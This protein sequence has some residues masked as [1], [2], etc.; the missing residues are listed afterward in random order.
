MPVPPLKIRLLRLVAI[1]TGVYLLFVLALAVFQRKLMYLPDRC[2]ETVALAKARD[3]RSEPWRD[4]QGTII[5]WRHPGPPGKRPANRLI[6]FHGNAG[7]ALDRTPIIEGFE[8]LEKGALWEGYLFEYPGYGARPG[9]INETSFKKAGA[10]ALKQLQAED[11]R[12]IFVIGE[13]VGS[14]PACALARAEPKSVAGL[15]LITPFTS[16]ADAAAS[17]YPTVPV[18][19]LVLDR[20]N[21]LAALP[22]YHGPVAMILAGKDTIIP[23]GEGKQLFAIANAPKRLWIQPEVDHNEIDFA[24][25]APWWQ[26]VSGFLLSGGKK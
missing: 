25:D 4:A 22:S 1:G 5:G 6:V 23:V 9:P 26:E 19:L 18:R 7:N 8:H 15:L 14:G 16:M 3:Y 13:S 12:P 2:T 21:N 20:W 17:H 24:P 10:A 11:S